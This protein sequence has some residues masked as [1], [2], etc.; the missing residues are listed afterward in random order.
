MKRPTKKYFYLSPAPLEKILIQFHV[1]LRDGQTMAELLHTLPT[2]LP[3]EELVLSSE[4]TRTQTFGTITYQRTEDNPNYS[5]QYQDWLRQKEQYQVKVKLYR[6]QE[7][8]Y[9]EWESL[10]PEEKLLREQDSRRLR[11]EAKILKLQQQLAELK[12]KL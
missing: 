4:F 1:E 5:A 11:Q 9:Q 12:A 2:D 10:T 3:L 8:L 7:K 6:Q